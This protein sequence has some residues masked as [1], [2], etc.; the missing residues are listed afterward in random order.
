MALT[1]FPTLPYRDISG[2]MMSAIDDSLM[3]DNACRLSLGFRY[4][5]VGKA[6]QRN[7]YAK[8]GG[9]V[10]L[11]KT[12]DGITGFV[13]SAQTRFR[14]VAAYNGTNYAFDGSTWTNIGGGMSAGTRVRYA[15]LLDYVFRVGGGLATKSWNGDTATSFGNDHLTGA[16]QGSLI[17]SFK[18]KL[19]IAGNSSLPDRL[20]FSTVPTLAGEITWDQSLQYLDVNPT[21]GDYI[22]A[23]AKTGT[24]ALVFK[25]N[26]IYRWNGT[27]TDAEPMINVGAI[28]QEVVAN[29]NG[30]VYFFNPR[31]VFSTDGGIPVEV[32]RPI[33]DFIDAIPAANY[34]SMCSYS[35]GERY[36]LFCGTVTVGTRTFTNLVLEYDTNTQIWQPHVFADTFTCF[37]NA[38]LASGADYLAGAK[39]TNVETMFTG[40][41]DDGKPIVFE[42]ETKR[43]DF[44]SR[45]STKEIN[46]GMFYL[47]GAPGSVFEALPTGGNPVKLGTALGDFTEFKRRN[48]RGRSISF[49]ISGSNKGNPA[50]WRGF[51]ILMARSLGLR[52]KN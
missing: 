16:P 15:N 10:E 23:L 18:S 20:Y 44:D 6:T 25:R 47:V 21:D 37:A 52:T 48:V 32:S 1:E 24:Q 35:D 31:G 38:R 34:P 17:L 5:Y 36:G 51:D 13:N 2:G 8:L 22:T 49:K 28:T 12:C 41:D 30:T 19:L 11:N 50:V 42:R 4:Q 9:T 39:T 29:V 14:V 3:P 33:K 40:N 45:S 26:F 7:G 43:F 46:D 27:S